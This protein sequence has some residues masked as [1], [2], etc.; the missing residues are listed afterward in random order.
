MSRKT[1]SILAS[2]A[3]VMSL[4]ALGCRSNAESSSV[5]RRSSSHGDKPAAA[6]EKVSL[7]DEPQ[8]GGGT[9]KDGDT[10]DKQKDAF[11]GQLEAQFKPL[12]ERTTEL[13]DATGKAP[14]DKKSDYEKS[15]KGVENKRDAVKADIDKV[16]S[17]AKDKWASFQKKANDDL[18]AY[19]DSVTV[20]SNQMKLGNKGV[21]NPQPS[22]EPAPQRQ[23]HP[24]NP[25]QDNPDTPERP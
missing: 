18:A 3:L 13:R 12:D 21:A 6:I 23:E 22:K 8:V 16:D 25:A 19:K 15:L 11:K 2:G 14:S 7:T 9:P 20:A 5:E 4:A 17:V 10:F 1:I 24:V